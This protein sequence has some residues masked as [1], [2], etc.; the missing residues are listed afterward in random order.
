M[1]NYTIFT[2]LIYY[3]FKTEYD[4]FEPK[5]AYNLKLNDNIEIIDDSNSSNNHL[6]YYCYLGLFT[7]RSNPFH[8]VSCLT[9]L[10]HYTSHPCTRVYPPFS[11]S[12][13][14]V[15]CNACKSVTR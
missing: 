9:S 3:L 1:Y 13:I 14:F 12:T 8:G 5:T 4:L 6:F 7:K 2:N 10:C 15:F 11:E